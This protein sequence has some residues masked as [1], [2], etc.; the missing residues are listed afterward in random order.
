MIWCYSIAT[1][2][3][4]ACR[5]SLKTLAVKFKD[6]HLLVEVETLKGTSLENLLVFD[7]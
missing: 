3:A 2:Y 1:K 7:V 5:L 6:T 4:R